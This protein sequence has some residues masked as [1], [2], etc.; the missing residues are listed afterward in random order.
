[1][2][3]G[4]YRWPELAAGRDSLLRCS[5]TPAFRRPRNSLPLRMT[6]RPQRPPD[7]R[8]GVP[9]RADVASGMD[10][11]KRVLPRSHAATGAPAS[12]HSVAEVG[13]P[14]A[15]LSNP[16]SGV[17]GVQVADKSRQRNR[18]ESS[19]RA[20]ASPEGAALF[21]HSGRSGRCHRGGW[22]VPHSCS[23]RLSRSRPNGCRWSE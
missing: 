21:R 9:V 20:I 17:D 10:D 3:E 19:N 22:R 1:M 11:P 5:R 23:R 18:P 15:S 12:V 4:R 16:W 13:L 8:T 14:Y 6:R 7:G 2:V